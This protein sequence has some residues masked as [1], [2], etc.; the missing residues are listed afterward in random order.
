MGPDE[1]RGLP[2]VCLDLADQANV[3]GTRLVGSRWRKA[4]SSSH[5]MM[6]GQLKGLRCSSPVQVWRVLPK[7]R[8]R[9]R[10]RVAANLLLRPG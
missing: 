7:D 8:V 10:K 5:V 6:R 2:T 1:F 3:A 4:E 9:L